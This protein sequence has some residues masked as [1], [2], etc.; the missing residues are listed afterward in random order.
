[1]VKKLKTRNVFLDTQV[2]RSRNFSCDG[3]TMR[4]VIELAS[5][6]SI[7]IYIDGRNGRRN[8]GTDPQGC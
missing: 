2:F 6:E 5:K 3:E 8:Q 4:K 1:M 7:H